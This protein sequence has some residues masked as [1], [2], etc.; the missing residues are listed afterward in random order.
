LSVAGA[1]RKG[2]ALNGGGGHSL[3]GGQG[4]K[5]LLLVLLSY[6][7]CEYESGG[8][9]GVEEEDMCGETREGECGGGGV[10]GRGAG[11]GERRGEEGSARGD[12][13]ERCEGGVSR[14]GGGGGEMVEALISRSGSIEVARERVVQACNILNLLPLARLFKFL[15]LNL[16][17]DRERP[18]E[19]CERSGCGL[20]DKSGQQE[21]TLDRQVRAR[22]GRRQEGGGCH[23]L[24]GGGGGARE[25]GRALGQWLQKYLFIFRSGGR[26]SSTCYPAAGPKK[27][28]SLVKTQCVRCSKFR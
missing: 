3:G 5:D 27:K 2:H 23:T 22:D 10:G 28:K 13:A 11:E 1:A 15:N 24:G 26:C 17:E 12:G 18:R 20:R 8:A 19:K 14:S 21:E 25:R 6:D 4:V 7:D 16:A 9:G